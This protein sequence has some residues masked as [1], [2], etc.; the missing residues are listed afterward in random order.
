MVDSAAISLV[1]PLAT[2]LA[3]G[4]VSGV[5][6]HRLNRNKEQTYFMRK[7][8]EDLYLAADEFG[9]QM[10]IHMTGFLPL[11]DGR[12]DYN[13]MLDNQIRNPPKKDHGGAE[14]ME[15]LTRIYFPEIEPQLTEL[16]TARTEFNK[17]TSAH[18][19]AYRAEEAELDDWRPLF[20]SA[21]RRFDAAEKALKAQIVTCG[22][23]HA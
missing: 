22:R 19:D 18:K 23:R 12:I 1:V 21:I 6:T 13:Q 11:I 16:F 5:V 20:V 9:R 2:V 7:K 3:S 4:V 10:A 17:V 14:T 15:M 8:A